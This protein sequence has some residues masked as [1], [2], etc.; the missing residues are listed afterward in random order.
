MMASLK[1]SNKILKP[2]QKCSINNNQNSTI[3]SNNNFLSFND[4]VSV[5]QTIQTVTQKEAAFQG[6]KS[7]K[8][9]RTNILSQSKLITE[10]E[11]FSSR[12]ETRS[13]N[14]ISPFSV[15]RSNNN[16]TVMSQQ[17]LNRRS[18]Q[19]SSNNYRQIHQSRMIQSIKDKATLKKITS[20]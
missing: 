2:K 7:Q 4:I 14:V 12:G 11:I 17:K 15:E 10:N 8:Q 16:N 9:S 3:T 5:N 19:A 18:V 1:R 20:R 6:V 13:K